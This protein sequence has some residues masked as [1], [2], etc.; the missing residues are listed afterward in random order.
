[1]KEKL[2]ITFIKGTLE[3]VFD[4][5]TERPIWR[6]SIMVNGEGPFYWM[7]HDA[8]PFFTIDEDAVKRMRELVEAKR[9]RKKAKR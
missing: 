6:G 5:E 9:M 4:L 1:M 7:V 3:K 8:M 2:N